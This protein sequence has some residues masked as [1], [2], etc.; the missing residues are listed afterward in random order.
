[1]DDEIWNYSSETQWFAVW[2]RSRQEKSA[3]SMLA[4]LGIPHFLP[5]KP[6]IHQWSDRKQTVSV[7][8]FSGYLFVRMDLA[9]DSRLKVLNTSGIVG[10]VGNQSGPMPIPDRQIADIRT[11]LAARVECAVLPLLNEGDLVRVYRGALA[12][13]EGRLV[14]SNSLSRISISIEM[15]H[16]SLLVNVSRD[17]VELLEKQNMAYISLPDALNFSG[18]ASGN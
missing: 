1:M 18:I 10:L 3:A 16:K 17:D 12:G 5:L 6:E 14:R 4:A 13:V 2:T 11:V 7:P 9:R 8:L 15:I